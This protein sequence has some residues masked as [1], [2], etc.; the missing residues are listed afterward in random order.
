MNA[1]PIFLDTNIIVYAYSTENENKRKVA[2][3]LVEAGNAVIS[4]QVLNEF[5]NTARRK[6]PQMFENVERT[7]KEL[8]NHVRIQDLTRSTTLQAMR[9]TRRYSYSFYDS[10]IIASALECGCRILASEDMQHGFV[11]DAQLRIENPFL[12]D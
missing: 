7:L 8:P 4:V 6:F 5:C 12:I 1:E 2:R 11:V 9:L 10:L 3:S